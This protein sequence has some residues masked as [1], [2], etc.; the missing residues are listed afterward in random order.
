MNTYPIC[1]ICGHWQGKTEADLEK[2]LKEEHNICKK[3]TQPADYREGMKTL[4][5][6]VAELANKEKELIAWEKELE[7]RSKGGKV[8]KADEPVQEEK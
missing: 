6:K 4:K 2:H 1:N 5:I 3:A 8:K 7:K